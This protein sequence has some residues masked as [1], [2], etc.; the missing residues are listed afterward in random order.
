M[1]IDA[2][3]HLDPPGEAPVPR[4]SGRGPIALI[5]VAG[6]VL[7]AIAYVHARDGRKDNLV[8]PFYLE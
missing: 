6:L 5:V 7:I 8:F 1:A 3:P 4:S 2:P